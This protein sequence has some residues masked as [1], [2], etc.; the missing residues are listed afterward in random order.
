MRLF[1]RRHTDIVD[2]QLTAL[3]QQQDGANGGAN[4]NN[5]TELDNGDDAVSL[6]DTIKDDSS[7]VG[8]C[9]GASVVS[10]TGSAMSVGATPKILKKSGKCMQRKK[11]V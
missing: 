11:F 4:N 2:P 9:A 10:R 1:R 8:S 6:A 7:V 5:K 3:R